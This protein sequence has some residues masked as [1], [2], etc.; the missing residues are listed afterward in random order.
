MV[1]ASG[2]RVRWQRETHARGRPKGAVA[3]RAR[4][5][6]HGRGRRCKAADAAGCRLRGDRACGVQRGSGRVPERPS[7]ARALRSSSAALFIFPWC[8]SKYACAMSSPACSGQRSAPWRKSRRARS[9]SPA[10]CDHGRR[11]RAIPGATRQGEHPIRSPAMHAS[12]VAE[13]AGGAG[14]PPRSQGSRRADARSQASPRPATA[15]RASGSGAARGSRGLERRP[16]CPASPPSPPSGATRARVP[17]RPA[18]R[19]GTARA[20]IRIGRA[21]RGPSPR[22]G[23]AAARAGSIT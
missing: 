9:C 12:R 21:A 23:S 19:G 18:Q 22:P 15:L 7:I 20:H 5:G 4:K 10:S 13:R 6:R 2:G 1:A 3:R 16:C 14:A 17:G 8:I 11:R